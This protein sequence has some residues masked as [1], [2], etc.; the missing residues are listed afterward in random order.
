MWSV[1]GVSRGNCNCVR[2]YQVCP[3]LLVAHKMPNETPSPR[4]KNVSFVA[5]QKNCLV[6][7]YSSTV[8]GVPY[9]NSYVNASTTI[10]EAIHSSRAS[11]RVGSE[12]I[13]LLSCLLP[14]CHYS[15][16][17]I[18]TH[19]R[20]SQTCPR[21]R[22]PLPV[23]SPIYTTLACCCNRQDGHVNSGMPFVTCSIC[24]FTTSSLP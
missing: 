15:I 3:V 18:L 12:W 22:I 16:N 6:I 13:V 24:A 10:R 9:V 5:E 11:R 4:A 19:D 21:Y 20:T 7:H 17:M 14:H 23:L 2:R 1:L 8:N